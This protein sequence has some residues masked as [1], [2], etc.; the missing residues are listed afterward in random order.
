MKSIL[1]GFIL[2]HLS[3]IL[4]GQ[5]E[6]LEVINVDS[7]A[8]TSE[9]FSV[10]KD[11][12]KIKEGKYISNYKGKI[13][14]KGQYYISRGV[15][16]PETCLN[17]GIKGKVYVSFVV[18]KEGRLE[19]AKIEKSVHPLIDQESSRVVKSSPLWT[20]AIFIKNTS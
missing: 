1:L 5:T 7:K 6:Y 8:N 18:N 19:D 13:Q 14:I 15:R 4:F 12:N 11:Q 20:P 2:I 16:Y 17:N 10:R 3:S 9:I